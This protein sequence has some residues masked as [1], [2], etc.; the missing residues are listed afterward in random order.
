MERNSDDQV[1][2]NKEEEEDEKED[3]KEEDD[4][5]EDNED[6]DDSKE[7]RTIGQGAIVNTLADDVS[8]MLDDQPIMLPEKGQEMRDHTPRPQL[9]VPAPLPQT[10]E[11][12]PWPG[13]AG[14]DPLGGLEIWA[15]STP[16]KPRPAV[17]TL[18]EAEAA[19][20]TSD[21]GVDQQLLSPSACFDCLLDFP[22]PD[23]ALLEARQD[24]SVGETWTSPRVSEE[25]MLIAFRS[26]RNLFLFVSCF[27]I[28]LYQ[29]LII[30]GVARFLNRSGFILSMGFLLVVFYS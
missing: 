3:D 15:L 22:D 1:E 24:G 20:N 23:V 8:T 21:T 16:Q 29:A 14:T 9:P 17:I 25:A 18:R 4:N 13:T 5:E 2:D 28:Y 19:R 10:S 7:P 26:G 27:G 30:S 6:E 11:P 12:S